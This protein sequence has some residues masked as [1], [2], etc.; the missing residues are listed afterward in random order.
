MQRCITDSEL[1]DEMLQLQQPPRSAHLHPAESQS[2]P[3]VS[4][5]EFHSSYLDTSAGCISKNTLCSPTWWVQI[6]VLPTHMGG[7]AEAQSSLFVL[8]PEFL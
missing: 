4:A 1:T 6:P 2:S 5:S 3:L 8:A 7:P